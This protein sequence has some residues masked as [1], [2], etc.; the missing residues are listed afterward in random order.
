[1]IPVT[2]PETLGKV[3]RHYRKNL[4]LTQVEAGSKFN[5]PQKTVSRIEAGAVAIRLD[6]VFKYM[7][8]LGLEMH[9]EPRDK[10]S[11]DRAPW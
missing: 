10:P 7:A 1:M 11:A 4:G 3:L 8:A 5:L 9:L 6:T 2:S